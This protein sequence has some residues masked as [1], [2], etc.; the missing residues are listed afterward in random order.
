MCNCNVYIIPFNKFWQAENIPPP[1]NPEIFADGSES[2]SVELLS[3]LYNQCYEVS[4][5]HNNLT[6]EVEKFEFLR[7]NYK[8]RREPS[9]YHVRLYNDDGK[10]RTILETLGFSVIG[11]SCF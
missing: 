7:G 5:D 4:E 6:A 2:D 9:A 10:Y 8:L 11:D 3:D 1:A